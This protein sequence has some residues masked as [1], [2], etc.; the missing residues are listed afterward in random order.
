MG[1][2]ATEKDAAHMSGQANEPLSGLPH[3]LSID[4]LTKETGANID[5][6][7][8]T[9]EATSRLTKYGRNELDEGPGVSPVKIF[10]RQVANAMTLVKRTTSPS[11]D[12]R[13]SDPVL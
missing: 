5:H 2:K 13:F 9:A 8:S 4:Q 1:S 12:H 11:P 7:L 6:G 3:T 10:V